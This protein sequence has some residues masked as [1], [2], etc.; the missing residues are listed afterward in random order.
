MCT[1]CDLPQYF[2]ANI[3]CNQQHKYT[4]TDKEHT[5]NKITTHQKTLEKILQCHQYN[6]LLAHENNLWKHNKIRKCMNQ[7]T[8]THLCL[9]LYQ[10]HLHG[11]QQHLLHNGCIILT[12][13]IEQGPSWEGNRSLASQ[14]SPH[15][16]YLINSFYLQYHTPEHIIIHNNPRT[17]N[18]NEHERI[19]FKQ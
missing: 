13:S 2:I 4:S 7:N 3:K 14:E 10:H 11:S 5:N 19:L 9:Y 15:T 8:T 18:K 17:L 16:H 1:N 6:T 12:N